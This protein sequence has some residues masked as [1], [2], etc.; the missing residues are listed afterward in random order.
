M[1]TGG[2]AATAREGARTRGTESRDALGVPNTAIG[3]R[4]AA[5]LCTYVGYK[6]VAPVR[7]AGARLRGT[8]DHCRLGPLAPGR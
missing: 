2:G 1:M 8:P 3:W 7:A 6:D 5:A 4:P